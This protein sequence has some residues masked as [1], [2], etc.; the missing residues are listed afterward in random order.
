MRELWTMQCGL[1]HKAYLR[2]LHKA[3]LGEPREMELCE[4]TRNTHNNH[5]SGLLTAITRKGRLTPKSV[6]CILREVGSKTLFGEKR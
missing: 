6:G 2:V 5:V 1:H 3:Y 4:Y